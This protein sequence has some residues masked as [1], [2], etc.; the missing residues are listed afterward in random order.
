MRVIGLHHGD[1]VVDRAPLECMH[2]R[3]PGMINVAQLRIVPAQLQHPSVLEPERDAVSVD[4]GDLG[5]VAVDETG[6]VAGPAD[7]VAGAQLHPLGAIDLDPAAFRPD[8]AGPPG[9]GTE[10]G[11]TKSGFSEDPPIL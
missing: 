5:G 6:V 8:L 2:G 4:R 11:K 7:A 3:G 9:N 1:H 10:L